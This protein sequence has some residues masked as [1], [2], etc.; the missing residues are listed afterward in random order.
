[1]LYKAARRGPVEIWRA[2]QTDT[3]AKLQNEPVHETYHKG[4]LRA[5]ADSLKC[6][7]RIAPEVRRLN[8][9]QETLRWLVGGSSDMVMR[10]LLAR[11]KVLEVETRDLCC[12]RSIVLERDLVPGKKI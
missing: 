11:W 9:K 5:E 12:W 1:M 2:S 4:E 6:G 7:G 3:P 10:F 8:L